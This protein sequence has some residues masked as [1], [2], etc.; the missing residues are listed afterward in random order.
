MTANLTDSSAWKMSKMKAIELFAGIGGFRVGLGATGV[1]TVWANDI[2]R[3]ACRVYRRHF[4]ESSIIEGDIRRI[5]PKTIPDHDILTA[6]FPCQPFSSAGK[7]EGI[8][9]IRGTL[10]QNIVDILRVKR[11]D[12]FILENVKRILTM[13]RGFHFRTILSALTD[14]DYF[15]EWRLVNAVNFGVPQNRERVFIIGTKSDELTGS[16]VRT[17][18]ERSVLLT[19]SE[20]S[21]IDVPLYANFADTLNPITQN[22]SRCEAWGVGYDGRMMTRPVPLA[23][24]ILPRKKLTDLLEVNISHD[25]KVD[26]TEVT[27]NRIE[28]SVKRGKM[29]NGVEIL[30]NQSGGARMGYTVFGTAGVAPTLTATTSRH[31]ERYKVGDVYRK[32]THVEYARLMGFPDDWCQGIPWYD[33]YSLFG[34]AVVPAIVEWVAS[35]LGQQNIRTADF[36]E[37]QTVLTHERF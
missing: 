9:D 17:L 14:L 5:D 26:F 13:E 4:G 37:R 16:L 24:D 25:Y 22:H 18:A 30:F 35:R 10:F 2:N 20:A 31:Y 23:E 27:K 15:V 11:P 8:R 28:G 3:N 29:V 12:V 32:L 6:G 34:N 33:Q 19:R 1:E 21:E 7:K 36:G